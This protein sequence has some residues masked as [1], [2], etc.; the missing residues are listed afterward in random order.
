MPRSLENGVSGWQSPTPSQLGVRAWVYV[1]IGGRTRAL[2]PRNVSKLKG[3][4]EF[5]NI[6]T[7]KVSIRSRAQFKFD[8]RRP[9]VLCKLYGTGTGA[10]AGAGAGPGKL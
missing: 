5:N 1:G 6:S 4:F 10:G 7:F 3:L 2:A 9:I 8:I